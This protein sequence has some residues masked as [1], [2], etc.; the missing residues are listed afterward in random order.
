MAGIEDRYKRQVPVQGRFR[1]PGFI[2]TGIGV[3]RGGP[4]GGKISNPRLKGDNLKGSGGANEPLK[5]SGATQPGIG[6]FLGTGIGV[7]R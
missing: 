6:E 3:P 1:K 7:G 5:P 4:G 2:G